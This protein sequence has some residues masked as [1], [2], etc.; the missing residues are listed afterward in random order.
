MDYVFVMLEYLFRI[1]LAGICGAVIGYERKNRGKGA[2][3]R[4][5][6]IVAIA[7][8]LMMVVSKYKRTYNSG[9]YMG[10]FG[11][12]YGDRKRNVYDRCTKLASYIGY[13]ISHSSEM[14]IF[15]SACRRTDCFSYYQR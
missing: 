6:I 1:L 12:R 11:Y 10:N 15:T 14:E 7:S 3:I 9:R 2:G 13:T 8:A 5:H 4:T